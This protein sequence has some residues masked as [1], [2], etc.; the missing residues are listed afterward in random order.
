MK[1]NFPKTTLMILGLLVI[2]AIIILSSDTDVLLQNIG[3]VDLFSL[4]AAIGLW[5]LS[6]GIRTI[7]WCFFIKQIDNRVPLKSSVLYYLAGFAFIFS[8]ARLGEIFK[9]TYIKRDFGI[10][11]SKTATIVLVERLYEIIGIIMILS[12]GLSLIEFNLIILAIP[13]V[14]L[15]FMIIILLNKKFF[16]RL[17]EYLSK[18]NWIKKLTPN[19]EESY[20]TAFRLMK[21]KSIC[22]GISTSFFVIL[23]QSI[24]IFL[25]ITGLE[26][27]MEFEKMLV[28]YPTSMFISAISMI[29]AGIGVFEGSLIGLL[30]YF[31]IPFEIGITTAVLVRLIAT[32]LFGVI[33]IVFLKIVSKRNINFSSN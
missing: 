6:N 17:F 31:E 18:I 32:G 7:R 30:V 13:F 22:V 14:I 29:P 19:L 4:L 5:S 3:K 2:Y 1:M 20:E 33:G 25:I 27:D 26:Q 21:P 12:I 10:S 28:I 24:T 16:V 9:S 11:I 15:I 23:L 8:P